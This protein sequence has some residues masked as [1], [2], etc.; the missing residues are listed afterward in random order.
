[1]QAAKHYCKRVQFLASLRRLS[2]NKVITGS[3]RATLGADTE[4]QIRGVCFLGRSISAEIALHNQEA[5]EVTRGK[6]SNEKTRCAI[7]IA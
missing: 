7:P 5:G 6:C 3:S 4:S 2:E 1:M